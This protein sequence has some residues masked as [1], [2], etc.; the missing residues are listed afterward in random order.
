[1]RKS[2]GEYL[3][4]FADALVL[5]NTAIKNLIT[6]VVQSDK[7]KLHSQF[8]GV[9]KNLCYISCTCIDIFIIWI[10]YSLQNS[11]LFITFFPSGRQPVKNAVLKFKLNT[12][13]WPFCKIQNFFTTNS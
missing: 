11:L 3:F 8:K 13:V 12:L 4:E 2:D 6:F 1:M 7:A 5:Y 10:W 9:E